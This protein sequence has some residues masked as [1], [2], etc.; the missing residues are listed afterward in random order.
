MEE[1]IPTLN[2]Y[3]ILGVDSNATPKQIKKKYRKAAH[4]YHPDRYPDIEKNEIL[5]KLVNEWFSQLGLAYKWLYDKEK[6]D[7]YNSEYNLRNAGNGSFQ[8]S[9]IKD[10]DEYLKT[11]PRQEKP[12]PKPKPKVKPRPKPKPKPEPKV[13]AK[14]KPTYSPPPQP[15]KE[16]PTETYYNKAARFFGS[17]FE[18]PSLKVNHVYD[19]RQDITGIDYSN[20]IGISEKQ[21]EKLK[22]LLL[23]EVI[24]EN[25]NGYQVELTVKGV[26]SD[27]QQGADKAMDLDNIVLL[28][29]EFRSQLGL[30]KNTYLST[31]RKGNWKDIYSGDLTIK[32]KK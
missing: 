21:R 4:K 10:L 8:K 31:Q 28:N 22:V 2:L 24:V 17:L 1:R 16:Q 13:K 32:K 27:L 6:R 23:D 25:E 26:T 19:P 20:Y 11:H 12:K 30:R 14:K 29:E 5:Y 9:A 7:D 18:G 15:K 3:E